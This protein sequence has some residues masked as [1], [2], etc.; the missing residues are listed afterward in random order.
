[1]FGIFKQDSIKS[2]FIIGVFVFIAYAPITI[3]D[4]SYNVS[5]S[6]SQFPHWDFGRDYDCFENCIGPFN[7]TID[8]GA[9]SDAI[10]P[11]IKLATELYKHGIIPLWNPYLGLG[12]PLAADSILFVYSPMI[13]F[14]LLNSYFWDI[15][16]L[17]SLW[18]AGYFTYLFL[19]KLNLNFISSI[20]GSLLFIFSGSFTWYLTHDS[21]LVVMFMPLILYSMESLFQQRSNKNLVIGSLGVSAMILGGHLETIAL[22]FFLCAF[23]FLFRIIHNHSYNKQ[24]KILNTNNIQIKNYIFKN[25]PIVLIFLFG[26]GLSGFFILPVSEYLL[27]TGVEGHDNT[28]GLSASPYFTIATT[29]IPYLLGTIH[30]YVS[31]LTNFMAS[32]NVLGGY[33]AAS[34]LF[35]I[36]A[37][38]FIPKFKN[39][40]TLQDRTAKFFLIISVFFLLK[41]IGIPIINSI[42]MLPVFD[43]VIFPRYD[44][45]LWTF[46]FT[47]IAAIGMH[48][49]STLKNIPSSKIIWS[50]ILSTS[51]ITSMSLLIIPYFTWDQL[52]GYY[53]IFQI[54]QSL[55]F[56]MMILI[57]ILLQK[58]EKAKLQS[59]LL[60]IFLE[61]S[62]YI[63]FGLHPIFQFYRFI[64]VAIAIIALLS[65]IL[66]QKRKNVRFQNY[67]LIIIVLFAISGQLVIYQQSPNALLVKHDSFLSTD[68]TNFLDQNLEYHRIFHLDSAFRPNFPAAYNIASIGIM[69]AQNVGW[70]HAFFKNNLDPYA[71]AT[72][73][74]YI[75]S[76]RQPNAPDLSTLFIKEKKY[77]DYLGIKYLIS[78]GTDPNRP[79]QP[80][81]SNDDFHWIGNLKN[82]TTQRFISNVDNIVSVGIKIGTYE[83]INNGEIALEVDSI[84]YQESLHRIMVYD[85]STVNNGVLNFFS[86]DRPLE[87]IKEKKFTLTL[88]HNQYNLTDNLLA[89][90]YLNNSTNISYSDLGFIPTSLNINNKSINGT[91]N[92]LLIEPTAFPLVYSNGY[93]V[94]ENTNVF[95]R[96]FFVK[97]YNVASSY[98]EA[99]NIQQNPNFEFNSQVILEKDLPEQEKTALKNS[100]SVDGYSKIISYSAND[101]IVESKLNYSAI[102]I[103]TDTYYPGW[104]AYV[105][106]VETEIYRANGLVRAIFVPAGEHTI[107]FSYMPDS[108]VY[109][110]IV[111]ITTG[112]IL[113]TSM[114]WLKKSNKQSVRCN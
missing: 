36:I 37:G 48:K 38:L 13:I 31:P 103:L 16:L 86:L 60:I 57:G 12:T 65:L 43:S 66:I 58:S 18:F 81:F 104:H 89:V 17:F 26:I 3:L 68:L 100:I 63:P 56:I 99:H 53:M 112:V 32:W 28:A 23:Y 33:F 47:V 54:L 95:T 82:A 94:F 59:I 110:I 30:V 34:G 114:I 62:L 71:L 41:S 111:S 85:A 45:F 64:P 22:V 14:Y 2:F 97:N 105:D 1:M 108:F 102:L 91:M 79:V 67:L 21:I 24:L 80:I 11:Q 50:G 90:Y 109:G 92:F 51:I 46:G 106:G 9:D 70:F 75:S 4:G 10:W 49:L 42:G 76:W 5:V 52:A 25:I 88:Y 69:E 20:T 77:Y 15:A 78:Q 72:N 87:N 98:N 29:F 55:F 83:R 8:P 39:L 61:L 7:F 96:T 84:P 74:D 40:S 35:L 19:R 113:I 101:I 44:G 6:S 73:F 93:L 27:V 107:K